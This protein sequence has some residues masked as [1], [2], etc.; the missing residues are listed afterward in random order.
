VLGTVLLGVLHADAGVAQP[1][2]ACQAKYPHLVPTATELSV[3]GG[4]QAVQTVV[5]T[6]QTNANTFTLNHGGV[7]SVDIPFNA[8]AATVEAAF[9]GMSTVGDLS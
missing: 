6:S 3:D 5:C 8:N 7:A 9:Q 1:S 2:L 4:V